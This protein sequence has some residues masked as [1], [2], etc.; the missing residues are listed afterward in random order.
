[1][2]NNN[3]FTFKNNII[4][5]RINYKNFYKQNISTTKKRKKAVIIK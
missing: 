4:Y 1:M 5:T 3:N 2:F